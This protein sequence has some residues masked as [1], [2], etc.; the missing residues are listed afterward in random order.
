[1][2]VCFVENGDNEQF[3]SFVFRT[4]PED[5]TGVAHI[6]EHSTLSGSRR[7]PVHDPFITL[8]KSSVN[9]YMNAM[10]YPDKTIYLASSPLPKD[11]DNLL[12]VYA[13]ALFAPLLRRETFEQEGVRL[14]DDGKGGHWEGVVF[15]EMLGSAN[16]HD[17]IVARG[18]SRSLFPD[19]CYAYESGGNPISIVDLSWERYKEFY[20]NHYA[21]G[22]CRLLVYGNNDMR[23]I[24]DMLDARYLHDAPHT[25][26]LPAPRR[27]TTWKPDARVR[28]LAPKEAGG[29][30][31]DASV[32]LGWATEPADDSLSILTLNTIVDLLLDD[33]SCPLYKA[34]LDSGLAEDISPESGMIADLRDMTFL[35]GFKGI[36]PARADEAERVILASLEQI[37]QEG[38]GREA[39]E[40]SLKRARFKQQEITGSVPMGLRILSRSVHGWM[41]GKGPFATMET[42]PVLDLLEKEIAKDCRYFEHWIEKHL[43]ANHHRV[44]VSVVPD[45]R[46]L[47]DQKHELDEKARAALN[48][49]TKEENRRF[50][51]FEDTAD[52]PRVL[53]TLPH[54][55]LSDLPLEIV[56]DAY[57]ERSVAA[58]PLW[59]RKQFTCGIDYVTLAIDVSDFTEEEYLPLTLYSRLLTM[60][61]CG[62]LDSRA[63][64]LAIKRL[65]GG[66]N[67]VTDSASDMRGRT[68]RGWFFVQMGF[69]SQDRDEAL[70]FAARLLLGADLADPARIKVALGD[71]KGDFADSINYNATLFASQCASSVF[72]EAAQDAERL[73]GIVQWNWLAGIKES[74]YAALGKRMLGIQKLLCQ[75]GRLVV[76]ATSGDGALVDA[77]SRFLGHFPA[78]RSQEAGRPFTLLRPDEHLKRTF[79][80]PSNVAYVSQVCRT[81]ETTDRLQVAQT[82]LSQ[83]LATGWLWNL[84]RMRGG[85]YGVDARPDLMERLF[86]FSSYRDPRI[87]ASLEDYRKSLE[88][89]ALHPADPSELEKAKISYVGIELRPKGPNQD[90]GTF[91]RRK[92][93]GYDEALRTKRRS[94]LISI[95][96]EEIQEGARVLAESL[97]TCDATVVFASSARLRQEFPGC[98]VERLPL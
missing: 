83:M 82:L 75:R 36:D 10:T 11:F 87:S 85:A 55:S 23:K 20:R 79:A 22:N 72:T 39:I 32:V 8:D 81:P 86:V 52:D 46:Y 61:G 27:S 40:S 56:P 54:L 58:V 16:D 73:G 31:G 97:A 13:D 66:F 57:D 96:P 18:V 59:W 98:R 47:V 49:G 76:G 53:A 41:D 4:L 67:V 21:S 17:S 93:Y 62:D 69:L 68:N 29:K 26:P 2:E 5:D 15:N 65:F 1:M 7:Y 77:L 25:E 19:T 63:V 92:L 64:S 74:D 91:F 38:I 51:A 6:L 88:A 30:R 3:F 95:S 44:L 45:E 43:L 50:Q 14:V 78:G 9:T 34:L 84:V 33:P 35:V 60:T 28:F 80:L 42:A 70:D 94:D 12:D 37:C 71:L 48:E 90:L 89:Q 24:L